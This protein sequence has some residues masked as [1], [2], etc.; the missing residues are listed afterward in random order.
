MSSEDEFDKRGNEQRDSDPKGLK[1][2]MRLQRGNHGSSRRGIFKGSALGFGAFEKRKSH[3]MNGY[4]SASNGLDSGIAG[5]P[6]YG[7]LENIK[8]E[9]YLHKGVAIVNNNK[10]GGNQM[11]STQI[12]NNNHVIDHHQMISPTSSQYATGSPLITR[13]GVYSGKQ[14]AQHPS[15]SNRASRH[16]IRGV[17]SPEDDS[18]E[19]YDEEEEE[20][21]EEEEYESE[22]PTPK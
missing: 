19:E 14:S 4:N 10:G 20:E 15:S 11:T 1:L 13:G 5:K 3:D 16:H 2:K 7:G 12:R 21:E 6:N 22:M 17:V 9:V 18:S 8:E